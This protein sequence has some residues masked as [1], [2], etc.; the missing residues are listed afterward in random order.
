MLLPLLSIVAYALALLWVAP[1]LV[2]LENAATVNKKP[3]MMLVFGLGYLPRFC[4]FLCYIM[5]YF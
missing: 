4:I 2:N 1:T 3:N 5:N